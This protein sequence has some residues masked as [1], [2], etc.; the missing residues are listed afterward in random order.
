MTLY[1][2]FICFKRTGQGFLEGENKVFQPTFLSSV[3]IYFLSPIKCVFYG[4]YVLC[5]ARQNRDSRKWLWSDHSPWKRGRKT[6]RQK[7]RA[8]KKWQNTWWIQMIHLC[9]Y[10]HKHKDTHDTCKDRSGLGDVCN[11]TL[12]RI[13]QCTLIPPSRLRWGTQNL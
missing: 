3:S 13:C 5:V 2:I 10:K 1:P 4:N 9:A 12:V 8:G 11:S 6:W 7:S